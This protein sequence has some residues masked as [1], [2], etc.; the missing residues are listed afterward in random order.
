MS[1]GAGR[2]ERAVISLVQA[3]PTNGF[4]V[5]ELC[6]RIYGVPAEKK[7]RV[8]V[9][10]AM[11]RVSDHHP[12]IGL[13]TRHGVGTVIYNVRSPASELMAFGKLKGQS[14]F[15]RLWITQDGR[16]VRP[17]HAP[18]DDGELENRLRRHLSLR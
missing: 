7:R 4:T 9:L 14:L 13:L 15:R 5:R 16:I 2:I 1:R 6:E 17:Y 11:K 18:A 10:R 3:E 8:S 12:D